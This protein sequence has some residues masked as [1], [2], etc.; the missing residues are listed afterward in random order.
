MTQQPLPQSPAYQEVV[1]G[2]LRMHKYTVDG[3][4]ES[5]EADALRESME[6]PWGRLSAVERERIT[7]LS[8]DLYTVSGPAPAQAPE[9]MNP[10]AQGKLGEAYEARERGEWDR[11]LEL[12]RRWGKF[13]PAPLLSYIRATIWEDAGDKPVAVIFFEHACRLDPQNENFQARYLNALKWTDNARAR[14]IAEPI[15]N[16]SEKHIPNL[17]IQAAEVLYGEATSIPEHNAA[18]IYRRLIG[19]LA[20]LLSRTKDEE[21]LEHPT[22]VS[23]ILLLLATCHR[24]LGETREAYDYYSRAIILEPW[25]DAL[26]TA[27]GMIV[28]GTNPSA[29]SDFE[30]AIKLNSPMVWP[31][32]YMAHYLL[33]QNRFEECRKMCERALG[34]PAPER[35]QSE[36][37]E[38]LGIALTHLGYPPP[39][40]QRAFENAIRVDPSNER[41]RQNLRRFL[42][43]LAAKPQRPI[44]WDQPSDNYIR[45]SGQQQIRRAPAV[46][47]RRQ[48][49]LV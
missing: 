4:E 6:E 36:L 2:L 49:E 40:I 20:P 3:Q 26:F 35:I 46:N 10:Q 15:L 22:Q 11:A 7:G 27:R 19:I 23:M 43:A 18:P 41:A 12:L 47:E 32:F 39:V 48:F 16:E 37:C 31:Y 17:V 45:N 1:R 25:N 14:T 13:V 30:Q 9:P 28:Y 21:G 38:F 33:S 5:E 8:K 34:K 24:W 29:I 42:D 44:H